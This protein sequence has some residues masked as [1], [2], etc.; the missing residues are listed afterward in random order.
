MII[1]FID[2]DDTLFDSG[3]PLSFIHKHFP[4]KALLDL[5]R[6]EFT[7]MK[8]QRG[9]YVHPVA[10]NGDKRWVSAEQL[11]QLRRQHPGIKP[12]DIG[13]TDRFVRTGI[14][15]EKVSALAAQFAFLKGRPDK[16]V[17]FTSKNQQAYRAHIFRLRELFAQQLSASILMV[18]YL[19]EFDTFSAKNE[20]PT[21]REERLMLEYLIGNKVRKQ[22]FV[23]EPQTRCEQAY[24]YSA[25]R[26]KVSA[27]QRLQPV[28]DAY[29]EATATGL[30]EQIHSRMT[31]AK[32][33][34]STHL[35]TGNEL[36]PFLNQKNP[37][38]PSRRI[39]AFAQY[40]QQQQPPV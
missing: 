16:V 29:I 13:I 37:L 15:E 34:Y 31:S 19:N 11:Q 4:E 12:V 10:Y 17:F 32:L 8:E 6:D 18:Y 7:L 38:L 1:H 2:L 30:Y 5:S 35:I 24:Y 25:A 3:M 28:F 14:N 23:D 26:N 21:E 9:K 20:R 40:K 39:R 27:V 33:E 36:N 22:Q